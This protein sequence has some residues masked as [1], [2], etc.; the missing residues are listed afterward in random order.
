[1]LGLH[2]IAEGDVNLVDL[3]RDHRC[4]V[5]RTVRIELDLGRDIDSPNESLQN[6]GL[7][8]NSAPFDADLRDANHSTGLLRVVVVVVVMTLM[9]AVGGFIVV[10]IV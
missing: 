7:G 2:G 6:H 8:A 1:L 9:V 3:T 4:D 10:F 5:C